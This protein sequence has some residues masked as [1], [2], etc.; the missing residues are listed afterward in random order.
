MLKPLLLNAMLPDISDDPPWLR[1]ARRYIGTKEIPGAAH[2]AVILKW[3]R[4]IRAPFVDDETPWC[5]AFV[6]GALEEVGIPS[7]RSASA[8]SYLNHGSRLTEPAYGC[9]VVFWRGKPGGWSGHVG[10]VVGRDKD[11]RLLVLGGNQKNM[12]GI[13]PFDT[14][15]ALGYRWPS[16]APR[17]DRYDL[18]VLDV[19]G[20]SSTNEA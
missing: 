14:G 17:R 4:M 2:N 9:I 10:F 19:S 11:H 20:A 15:R 5:A 18:P 12:V 13:D 1:V 8:R 7:S 6:G 3:W 16:V